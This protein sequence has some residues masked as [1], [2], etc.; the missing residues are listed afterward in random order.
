M[1]WASIK[2]SCAATNHPSH[3]EPIKLQAASLRHPSPSSATAAQKG[4]GICGILL[5]HVWLRRTKRIHGKSCWQALLAADMVLDHAD[6]PSGQWCTGIGRNR[7]CWAGRLWRPS[8]AAAK[9]PGRSSWGHCV[10]SHHVPP[11]CA[12][13]GPLFPVLIRTHA[14]PTH[15]S[16]A[17]AWIACNDHLHIPQ[18]FLRPVRSVSEQQ[19]L[20]RHVLWRAP[21]LG[22]LKASTSLACRQGPLTHRC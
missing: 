11:C 4:H 3:H 6:G 5:H 17:P 14:C 22:M 2:L 8:R 1:G 15:A 9:G 12:G 10:H 16:R 21:A 7:C 13:T 20:P 18:V 19:F